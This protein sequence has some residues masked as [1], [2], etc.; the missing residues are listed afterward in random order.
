[1]PVETT[2]NELQPLLKLCLIVV[3]FDGGAAVV[4]VSVMGKAFHRMCIACRRVT[5]KYN[6]LLN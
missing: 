1:M 5:T 6:E 3:M 4:S 2:W